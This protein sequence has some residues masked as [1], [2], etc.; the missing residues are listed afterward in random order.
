MSSN[1]FKV[2]HSLAT[3]FKYVSLQG[4]CLFKDLRMSRI[5]QQHL[6]PS[7]QTEVEECGGD[8]MSLSFGT[9]HF[10]VH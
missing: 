1:P 7:V 2:P 8:P 10:V 6:P 5:K 3:V 9:P 4:P